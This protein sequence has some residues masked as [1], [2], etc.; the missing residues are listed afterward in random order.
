MAE[1]ERNCHELGM[2]P[3]Q[4]L[5]VRKQALVS[6]AANNAWKLDARF[7]EIER[8]FRGR[9]RTLRQL[10][11]DL[12]VPAVHVARAVLRARVERARPDMRQRDRRTIVKNVINESDRQSVAE[13]LSDWEA[14]QLRIAKRKDDIGYTSSQA[15]AEAFKWEE[16]IHAFLKERGVNFLTEEDMLAANSTNTPDVLLLDD[17]IINGRPVR[18][19][20]AKNYYGSGLRTSY[21]MVNKTK[22]TNCLIR[23]GVWRERCHRVQVRVRPKVCAEVLYFWMLDRFKFTTRLSEQ[24]KLHP[25]EHMRQILG[26]PCSGIYPLNNTFETSSYF[27]WINVK[28]VM[29]SIHNYMISR[30]SLLPPWRVQN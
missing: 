8:A 15:H 22:K 10:S 18:W 25:F 21:M 11:E 5:L 17:C 3:N 26:F 7:D 14:D 2:T 13:F 28:S 20:D 30:I 27:S 24:N 1:I 23:E 4:G 9:R 16:A 19:I 29:S 6:L 12:D